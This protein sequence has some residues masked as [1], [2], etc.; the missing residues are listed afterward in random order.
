MALRLTSDLRHAVAGHGESAYP[1]ECCGAMLGD[2]VGER[3]IVR[4]LLPIENA[5]TDSPANR[6]LVTDRDYMRSERE[7]DASGLAL[8]G[9]YHSH[10]DHPARPSETDLR[11]AF[12]NFSYVIV[13]VTGGQAEE[14]TSWVLAEDRTTFVREDILEEGCA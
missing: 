9:F 2:V 6:F 14:M 13:A 1:F 12:P 5:R 4:R 11:G 3:R 8:L 10:P 7:A